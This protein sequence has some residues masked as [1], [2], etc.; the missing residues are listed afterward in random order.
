MSTSATIK[1]DN[2]VIWGTGGSGLASGSSPT[3][4]GILQSVRNQLTGE[5]VEIDD[6]NGFASSI[7]LFNHKNECDFT[8]VVQTSAPSFVRGSVLTVGGTANVI[9]K[10]FEQMWD[11]K[12]VAKYTIRG[13][14]Y[15]GITSP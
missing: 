8:C 5:E 3:V 6:V 2:T 10:D 14:A 7:V 15:A 12:G 11:N 4:T 1:G 13:V 9:V